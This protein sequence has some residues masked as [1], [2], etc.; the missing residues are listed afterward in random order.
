PEWW[1]AWSV[2]FL[3]STLVFW[4]I[5]STWTACLLIFFVFAFWHGNQVA[6]D[7]GYRRSRQEPFDASEHTV[8]LL[9]LSEPK[10][11]QLRAIQRFVGLVSCIDN[12]SV[13]FQVSAEC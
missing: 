7:P 6:T 3:V 2:A 9:V 11:D 5:R 13:R 12:R 10:I 1:Q 4:K 8:T